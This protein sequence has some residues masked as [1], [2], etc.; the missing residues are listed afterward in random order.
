MK[1][2][3]E[4]FDGGASNDPDV[5]TKGPIG[6]QIRDLQENLKPYVKKIKSFPDV[7]LPVPDKELLQVR[8]KYMHL[9]NMI[10]AFGHL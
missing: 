2:M 1:H 9:K 10:L 7:D 6:A 3:M 8:K 4:F 5:F